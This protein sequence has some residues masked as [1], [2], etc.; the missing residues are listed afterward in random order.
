MIMALMWMNWMMGLGDYLLVLQ[1]TL[2]AV[3]YDYNLCQPVWGLVVVAMLLPLTQARSLHR[4]RSLGVIHIGCLSMVM[5]L[6]LVSMLREQY[7]RDRREHIPVNSTPKTRMWPYPG[8]MVGTAGAHPGLL[9]GARG[10]GAQRTCGAGALRCSAHS[11]LK[12][13]SAHRTL[14]LTSRSTRPS[15]LTHIA[16]H[17]LFFLPPGVHAV[18]QRSLRVHLRNGGGVHVSGG[19][20][21]RPLRPRAPVHPSACRPATG[22]TA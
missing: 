9:K 16:L 18:R 12:S 4:I 7:H 15:H 5:L 17:S 21:A 2:Q 11:S 22:P 10:S 6:V 14:Y 13:D 19:P 20:L 1:S 8:F 3:L